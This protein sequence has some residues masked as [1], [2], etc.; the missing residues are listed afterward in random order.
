MT[1]GYLDYIQGYWCRWTDY[2]HVLWMKLVQ[3][4]ANQ[5]S[6]RLDFQSSN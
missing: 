1:G 2:M 6:N 3:D 5:V 4:A